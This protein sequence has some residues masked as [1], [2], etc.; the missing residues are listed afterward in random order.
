MANSWAEHRTIKAGCK[1]SSLNS[2]CKYKLN[3]LK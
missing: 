2:K 3:G 1:S